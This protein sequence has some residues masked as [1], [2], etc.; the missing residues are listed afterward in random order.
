M[1]K[2]VIADYVEPS[3][4]IR[5]TDDSIYPAGLLD[6]VSLYNLYDERESPEQD[7]ERILEITYPTE[8][9]DTIIRNTA[10][11]LDAKADFSEGGQIVGGEYGSGKSH[12]ELVVYHLFNSPSLGQKW[13]NQQGIDTTLPDETCATALQMFNLDKGYN[14]LSE[15]VGDYLGI[16][17]W[18][19]SA[20]LP[21]V[22]RFGTRSKASRRSFSSTS[23][24]ASSEWHGGRNIRVTT[25]HSF[26]IFSKP[27]TAMTH[28]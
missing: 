11:K 22:H 27:L 16:D 10:R 5:A 12:I 24:S 1:A 14:R 25:S 20:D 28:N 2:G 4:E 8:T 7:A 6:E 26:K 21:T 23:L 19:E 9:L 15:A 18:A 3:D 17:E 13:L